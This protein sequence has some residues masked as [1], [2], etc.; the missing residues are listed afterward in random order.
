MSIRGYHLSDIRA[1]AIF[2]LS[3]VQEAEITNIQK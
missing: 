2:K 3:A 1:I